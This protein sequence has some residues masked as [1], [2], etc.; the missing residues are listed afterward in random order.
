MALL[1]LRK[2]LKEIFISGDFTYA[3]D[4]EQSFEAVGR[5]Y[6]TIGRAAVALAL[7]AWAPR[8]KRY[9]LNLDWRFEGI[10]RSAPFLDWPLDKGYFKG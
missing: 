4:K 3:A 7:R 2:Y 9:S 5:G 8:Q 10:F 6:H 1:P